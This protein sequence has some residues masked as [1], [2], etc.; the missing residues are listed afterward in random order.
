MARSRV[1]RRLGAGAAAIVVMTTMGVAAPPVV[2]EQTTPTVAANPTPAD[3]RAAAAAASLVASRPAALHVG[4]DDGFV[5]LPVISSLGWRYV[6]YERTYR[7]LPV[8]GGDFVV[9]VD[10]AGR[11]SSTSVAQTYPIKGIGT[12]PGVTLTA[13]KTT[14]AGRLRSVSKVG[15]DRLVV[16]ALGGAARLAWESTVEGVG[17]GGSSRLTVQVDALTGAVLDSREYVKADVGYGDT[18]AWCTS[19]RARQGSTKASGS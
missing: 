7:G 6:P 9:V 4:P 8:V 5:Q 13:A 16:Y 2:A 14:A 1:Q 17:S 18:T 10:P 3:A 11:V 12:T 19:A 15:N